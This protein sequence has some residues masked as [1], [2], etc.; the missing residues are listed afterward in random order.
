MTGTTG[1]GHIQAKVSMDVTEVE[2]GA[3]TA[4]AA[5]EGMADKIVTSSGKANKS[6]TSL[7][8]APAKAAE[9]LDRAQR[10]MVQGIERQIAAM[11][12]G[13][14]G[15][16]DFQ[17]ALAQ[18]RGVEITPGMEERLQRLKAMEV[19]QKATTAAVEAAV[20]TM[21]KYEMSQKAMAAAMRNVPAQMTD[22]VVGLQGGQKPLTVLLQQGGQLKDMFG[23][24]GPAVSAIGGYVAGLIN[25][26]TI[27]VAVAGT[28]GYAF[29][30]GRKEAEEFN[31]ALVQTNDYAGQTSGALAAMAM[32][33]SQVT[34]STK[35]AAAEAL[36]ALAGSGQLSGDQLEKMAAAAIRIQRETG[37]AVADT[38]KQFVELGKDPVGASLKLN[39]TMHYL[40]LEV[41]NQIKALD[42][43]GKSAQA[44]ALAQKAFADASNHGMDNL[45]ANLGTLES[46]TRD[47]GTWFKNMWDSVLN[48]GRETTPETKLQALKDSLESLKVKSADG[49]GTVFSSPAKADAI[50]AQMAAL[51]TLVDL[52]KQMAGYDTADAK[53]VDLKAQFDKDHDQ[54]LS[55]ELQQRKELLSAENKYKG[56]VGVP[57]GISTKDYGELR[58]GIIKKY[59]D[60]GEMAKREQLDK[61]KA[62]FDEE[63]I[64]KAYEAQASAYSNG[65]KILEGL[66]SAGVITEK[67]YY[68]SKRMFLQLTADAEDSALADEIDRERQRKL[69]G[70]TELDRQIAKQD[71]EKKIFDLQAQRQKAR[72]TAAAA[73]VILDIQEA[74]GLGKITN[75]YEEARKAAQDY[76]DTLQLGYDRTLGAQSKG[77][78]QNSQDSAK[79]QIIDKFQGQR[80]T[81]SQK[82]LKSKR[83][84]QD[85]QDYADALKVANEAQDKAI[86]SWEEYYGKLKAGDADWKSGASRALN[87][88][89]DDV[90]NVAKA[91]ENLFTSAFKGMEDALV[92]WATTGKDVSRQLFDQIIADIIR[93]QV[94]ASV[95]GP[96]ASF[97]KSA[98]G[99]ATGGVM[100]S[101]G[102]MPLKAYASGGV[103][104][105][106][107]LALFG[108][109]SMNEAFVP[110][111]D[112]KRI[113]VS[114]KGGGGGAVI[115]NQPITI[116]APNASA[117]T[118]AQIQSM[119]PALIASNAKV[120]EGVIRQAMAKR[121]G[122][123]V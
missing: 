107:Q 8:D 70:A 3:Q 81:A 46:A 26:L 61:A 69:I 15:T 24:I 27:A 114:L 122:R 99:F 80:D 12:A 71:Q 73:G 48:I 20:P 17:R 115:V 65:E 19:Q 23:G 13:A 111:P 36:A 10:S 40:T 37:V 56:L 67:D 116:S 30:A 120:V 87:N 39:S 32:R 90:S 28:L 77:T 42:E 102:P 88:Y 123:L 78:S 6:L 104:T 82:Y 38:V 29:L 109:G 47:V 103:A 93:M 7:G 21:Q 106:P 97:I 14:K 119:M 68:D 52:R 118:V 96:A 66:R 64:K 16:A 57:G 60:T 100:T 18:E 105:S 22:I 112:G 49:H 121:A 58:A 4:G 94:R 92:T 50:K 59:T 89:L 76:L 79:N 1:A 25:P 11:A 75:A 51:Q 31:K 117:Q 91:S 55:K 44:A 74:T 54:Y 98:F 101:D 41:Y 43:Q 34:G 53:Q 72:A 95:T 45:K 83:S 84:A 108:E 33:V 62:S 113:P 63:K 86:A 35:G 5:V 9:N 110:L 85:A 2:K